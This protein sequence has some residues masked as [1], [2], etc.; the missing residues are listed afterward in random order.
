[1]LVTF[2][3]LGAVLHV[4]DPAPDS[5]VRATRVEGLGGYN[6]LE[7]HSGVTLEILW[8]IRIRFNGFNVCWLVHSM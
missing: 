8:R 6:D 1:M 3:G 2:E 5:E 4:V 7:D